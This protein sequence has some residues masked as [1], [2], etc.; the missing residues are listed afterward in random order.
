MVVLLVA[1]LFVVLY[2]VVVKLVECDK[3][4]FITTTL[5]IIIYNIVEPYFPSEHQVDN[6]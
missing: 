5:C 2:V 1:V 6:P 3:K 4:I